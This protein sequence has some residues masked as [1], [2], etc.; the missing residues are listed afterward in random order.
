MDYV[1]AEPDADNE[2][3]FVRP[4]TDAALTEVKHVHLEPP[5]FCAVKSEPQVRFS[6]NEYIIYT[7]HDYGVCFW[8]ILL[9]DKVGVEPKKSLRLNMSNF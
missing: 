6:C 1:K 7:F 4:T 9:H 2:S 5:I 8:Y 3:F